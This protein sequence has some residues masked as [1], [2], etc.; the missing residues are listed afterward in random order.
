MSDLEPH[1]ARLV[2]Q[3]GDLE[4]L[5]RPGRAARREPAISGW[6]VAEH[7]EHLLL[8][9]EMILAGLDR[10]DRGAPPAELGGG[11]RLLGRVVLFTGWIP[12]GRGTAPP[13][14]VPGTVAVADLAPRYAGLRAGF[15]RLTARLAALERSRHTIRHPY[16]GPFR[17]VHWLEFCVIHNRH[18]LR[19]AAEIEGVA[20]T[21]AG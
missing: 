12:R 17:A 16:F 3:L 18:H 4:A 14:T 19:I 11:P 5:A 8:A 13:R 15:G 9:A 2:A 20:R 1:L 10:L 21:A 6:S 7:L